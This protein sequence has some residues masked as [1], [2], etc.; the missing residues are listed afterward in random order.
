[1]LLTQRLSRVDVL[2]RN[3]VIRSYDLTY[4][5]YTAAEGFTRLARVER[6]GVDGSVYPVEFDFSYTQGLQQ[7]PVVFDMGDLGVNIGSGRATLIDINGDALPDLVDSTNDDAHRFFINRPTTDGNSR[8]EEDPVLSQVGTGSAFRL[9]SATVQVFDANGDGFSDILN[10]GTGELLLNLGGGDWAMSAQAEGVEALAEAFSADFDAED[11]ELQTLKF[12]DYNNDKRIDVMRSTQDTTTIYRNE[13]ED[14]FVIEQIE[15]IGA[16]F[17]EDGV[18]FTDM[19]G[20]GLLDVTWV[21]AGSLRY[22]LN[23]GWGTWGEWVNITG[24]PVTDAEVE[25]AELEDINGDGLSDVVVVTGTSVKY[26]LNT[27]STSFAATVTLDNLDVPERDSSVTVLYADMNGNGSS[28]IVWVT[29]QG[30]VTVL[31]LF[32]VRPNMLSQ[33]TNGIGQIERISYRSSVQEMARDSE[34]GRPWP[35]KLPH[36]MQVVTSVVRTDALTELIE[37]DTYRYHN[38]YYDGVEKQ[39]R[40]Y[41]EVELE[42]SF[43]ETVE[44]RVV[45][46]VYEVGAEDPYRKGLLL[47]Q[48][49]FSDGRELS[50]SHTTYSDCPVAQVPDGTEFPVRFITQQQPVTSSRRASLRIGGS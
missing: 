13:G 30:S 41:E 29:S 39:F 3:Q 15:S 9:Q 20:D 21:R 45:E 14:G 44:A 34:A 50:Q 46:M 43:D 18:Q 23:Y 6:K 1:M 36:P 49:T 31:E 12:I 25:L 2:S 33:I 48:T 40:G 22:R 32:P 27:N 17:T 26:A 10:A 8:F 5:S 28:D 38:G 4:E 24:L 11:G 7:E 47:S 42:A 35:Y 37:E 19:N 16:G